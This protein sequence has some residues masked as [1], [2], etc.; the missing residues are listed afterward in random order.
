MKTILSPSILAA[1]FTRLGDDIHRLE[2]AGADMIHIDVMDGDFV[3]NMSFGA[4]VVKSLRPLT[5]LP[6]DAHLMISQPDRHLDAFADAGADMLT[7]HAEACVHLSRTIQ[8]IAALGMKPG[9]ALN[10][11]TPP[12]VLRWVLG[13]I[14][15]ILIMTVN[16]GFGGQAFIDAM[17]DK[18]K[19]ARALV[20]GAGLDI[21]ISIGVDGGISSANVGKAVC[22]GANVIVAG[23]AVFKAQD[24]RAE[25]DA[26]RAAGGR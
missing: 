18:I 11:H 26:Y 12:E 16:P 23:S 19:A 20:D 4:P 17:Y 7:V 15:H 2:A 3:P 21:G 25:L 9:V 6:F 24:M 1:D 14:S 8:R 5:K 10:P 22:A 13:D